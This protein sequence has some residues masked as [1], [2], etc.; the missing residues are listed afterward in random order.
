MEDLYHFLVME[1][2][3]NA[4]FVIKKLPRFWGQPLRQFSPVMGTNFLF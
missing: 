2:H 1:T 4:I 3:G